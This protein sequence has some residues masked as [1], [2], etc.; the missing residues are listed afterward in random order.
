MIVG[1]TTMTIPERTHY[2][3]TKD[4]QNV[5]QCHK[6]SISS[7]YAYHK[8]GVSD[9]YT[10]RFNFVE[11]W[12]NLVGHGGVPVNYCTRSVSTDH[13]TMDVYKTV[14]SEHC[15]PV[16]RSEIKKN[17]SSFNRI[18]IIEERRY[19]NWYDPVV[20]PDLPAACTGV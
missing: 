1:N 18:E 15:Y 13:G 5:E 10:C 14:T 9:G 3:Y 8:P 20:L 16:R 2:F 6:L 17:T 19:F 7:E 11:G 12:K 4:A